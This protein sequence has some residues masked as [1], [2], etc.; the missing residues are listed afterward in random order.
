MLCLP[1]TDPYYQNL[2]N[3]LNSFSVPSFAHSAKEKQ[4]KITNTFL[5]IYNFSNSEISFFYA[6]TVNSN[7]FI[8]RNEIAIPDFF[9][10]EQKDLKSVLKDVIF[11]DINSAAEV[12]DNFLKNTVST[13]VTKKK[14]R[15]KKYCDKCEIYISYNHWQ[16]HLRTQKHLNPKEEQEQKKVTCVCGAVLA[17]TSV[18]KHNKSAAHKKFIESNK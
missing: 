2:K 9:K 14:K 16:E 3:S 1:I 10:S 7:D 17:P 12:F 4:Q 18:N 13:E 15:E 11:I 8:F 6:E 5:Y